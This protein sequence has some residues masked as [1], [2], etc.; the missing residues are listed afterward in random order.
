MGLRHLFGE[1]ELQ[2]VFG[3]FDLVA[4]CDVNRDAAEHVAAEAEKGL[5]TRPR[6]Y[7]DFDELLDRERP[8]AVDIVTDAGTHHAMALKAFEAGVHVAVEKPLALTVRA[9]RDIIAA[10]ERAGRVLSVLENYRRDPMIRLVK[11]ILDSRVLGEPRL[12]LDVSASG[13]RSMPHTTAWRHLKHRG[14]FLLDYAIH[15]A[16]LHMYFLGGVDT[17]YAETAL[18]EKVR[19]V[20]GPKSPFMAEMYRHRVQEEIERSG[21][22]ETTSEDM[23]VVVIRFKSGAIGQMT[24]TIAA[25]GEGTVADIIYCS[26]GSIRLPGARTGRPVIVTRLG[27]DAPLPPEA[28]LEMVPDFQ[29]D[30]LTAPLFDDRRRLASYDLG[31]RETDRKNIAIELQD[32]GRAIL[33]GRS[34]EVTGEIG[35]TAV[36]LVYAMLESG[37][38]RRPVSFADVLE[39]RVNAYQQVANDYLGL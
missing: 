5:G 20:D 29:L 6:V 12:L 19:T 31:T 25:P 18:W 39:D 2:R 10:S 32:F 4:L 11:A 34:P 36:A 9:G 7:T 21:A 27:D 13:T 24:M 22:V 30:D 3:T 38:A 15:N 8:D 37:Q 17:V 1:V 23:A 33:D 35:L 28:A 14:G 16:D 26:K